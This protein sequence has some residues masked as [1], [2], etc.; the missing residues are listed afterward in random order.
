LGDQ[1]GAIKDGPAKGIDFSI[2]NRCIEV[3]PSLA[4]SAELREGIRHRV[5][6]VGAGGFVRCSGAIKASKNV[7]SVVINCLC[8]RGITCPGG[9]QSGDL[10][11]CVGVGVVALHSQGSCAGGVAS[12]K[13]AQNIGCAVIYKV[14][15]VVGD[16]HGHI[17]SG[18]NAGSSFRVIGIDIP[19]GRGVGPTAQ[20][21]DQ[22]GARVK[23]CIVARPVKTWIGSIH[24]TTKIIQG[25]IQGG[26][27]VRY[28]LNAIH[29][30]G[31]IGVLA[32]GDGI[33]AHRQVHCIETGGIRCSG[34][35]RCYYR[36]FNGCTLSIVDMT[37]QRAHINIWTGHQTCLVDIQ[38]TIT[39]S[40]IAFPVSRRAAIACL[41]G[42]VRGVLE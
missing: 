14:D 42:W 36:A 26:G 38:I 2:N 20:G 19:D 24:P 9:R 18:V 5:I 8:P 27:G 33:G 32:G 4:Q 29:R 23:L 34:T 40:E 25:E 11:G 37:F 13:G 21:V 35:G 22:T 17:C 7:H 1:V 15:C 10:G 31:V 12:A 28:N 39:V 30:L 3:T 6:T 41:N 16:R